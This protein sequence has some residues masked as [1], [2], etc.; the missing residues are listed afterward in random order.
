MK[1]FILPAVALVLF[2]FSAD[3]P[4]LTD[5]ERE[6]VNKH[7]TETRD[8]MLNVLDDLTDEQLNFKPDET[9]WSI[10]EGVEHL[11]VVESTFRGLIGKT[12]AAGP[13][14]AL[15]DSLAFKDEQIMP[16]IT[17]RSNK[18]K[19]SEPFEPSGKFG[20]HE[21]T[22]QAFLEKRSEL[23]DYVKT[24]DDDLRNRYNKDLPFGT[25]DGVQLIMFTA[26]HTER[27]VL[28]MEEVMAHSDFPE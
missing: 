23:I 10:A 18:V 20:S 26:A 5:A 8:H 3:S 16:V 17:D 12:V 28:Q 24:T 1:K 15:K 27:H 14:P 13:N 4:K 6:M 9:T 22:L 25:V 2:S 7:L 19:T 21:E 11:A